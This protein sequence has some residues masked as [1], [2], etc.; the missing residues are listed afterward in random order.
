[1]AIKSPYKIMFQLHNR[2]QPR[3][4]E[5]LFPNQCSSAVSTSAYTPVSN[6]ELFSKKIITK[7]Y[8][9]KIFFNQIQR[10]PKPLKFQK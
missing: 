9:L 10:E 6:E 1:M 3:L 8:F 4:F 2:V 7:S 5:N